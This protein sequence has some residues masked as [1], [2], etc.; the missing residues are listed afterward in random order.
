MFSIQ[1]GLSGK[2]VQSFAIY[3]EK[4]FLPITV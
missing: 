4:N 3:S 1:A 2:R